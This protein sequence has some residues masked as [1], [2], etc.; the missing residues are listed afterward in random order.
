[1]SQTSD[2]LPVS[3]PSGGARLQRVRLSNPRGM[4][5]IAE[6]IGLS[7]AAV[8]LLAVIVG[9]FYFLR[10]AETRRATLVRDRDLL[11]KELRA[12]QETFGRDQNVKV[13]IQKIIASIQDFEANGLVERNQGRMLLYEDLNELLRKNGLRNTSGPAYAPLDPLGSKTQDQAAASSNSTSSKW[14]T[15][16]PGI[17][18]GVTVEGQYQNIRHFVRDIEVSKGFLIIN[19]VELERAT[20]AGSL[21]IAEPGPRSTPGSALVSLRLDLATYFQRANQANE[22][23]SEQSGAG[24]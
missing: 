4:I 13:T 23:N 2:R 24:H 14:Q 10:P 3:R 1:M 9:Y 21:A 19:A 22:R 12:S 17:A 5:G 7:L 16:Y 6:L 18:V 20:E 8:L 15:I 11:Q